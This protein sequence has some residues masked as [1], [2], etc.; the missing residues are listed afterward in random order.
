MT[1]VAAVTGVI[2]IL[3]MVIPFIELPARG[4]DNMSFAF[5]IV[6]IESV[7]TIIVTISFLL[8]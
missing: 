7:I 4:L 8:L 3:L 2:A 1:G 6:R 5:L